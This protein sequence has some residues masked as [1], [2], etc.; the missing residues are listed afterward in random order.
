MAWAA[1]DDGGRWIVI[2][3][4]SVRTVAM[5]DSLPA[6]AFL[7]TY[8]RERGRIRGSYVAEL[9]GAAALGDLWLGGRLVDD[10]GVARPAPG[11]RPPAD[12]VLAEVFG[13]V[14]ARPRRWRR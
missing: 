11:A 12:P 4:G 6:R 10:D 8:D 9:L 13:R 1:S 14:S 5:P 7:L 3:D 2:T